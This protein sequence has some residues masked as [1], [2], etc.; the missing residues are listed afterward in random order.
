MV[1][2]RPWM[3]VILGM[4]MGLVLVLILG[5]RR[6]GGIDGFYLRVRAEL[7]LP[8]QEAFVPTPLPTPTRPP[9]ATVTPTAI[10][11]PPTSTATP[12][13][14]AVHTPEPTETLPPTPTPAPTET[15]TPTPTPSFASAEPRVELTGLRHEWQ[16]WNNCGPA[17]LATLMSYYGS[18]LRQADVAAVI[19]PDADVRH[20]PYTQILK[21]ARSQG[22]EAFAR[23]NGTA[24]LLKLFVS[25]DMPVMIPTWHVDAKGTGMGHYRVVTGY[26]D[27]LGEWILY[28]S[29]ESRGI[30]RDAPYRGI[31]MSYEQLE[32]YW[33]VRNYTY[34]VIVPQERLQ[35]AEAIIGEDMDN[36]VMWNASL[37]RAQRHL[38]TNRDD[39]FAWFSLG[40]NL[41]AHERYEE[42]AGAFDE[43]RM[44]GL[45]FRMMWYQSGPFTAYYETGRLQEV[46]AL[47]DATIEVTEMVES[48]HY[49]RGMA[50][51]GLGDTDGARRA[52]ERALKLRADF[53][54]AVAALDALG[55]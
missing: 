34:L 8:R 2:F 45:P 41:L 39:A 51:A 17:S 50:L 7:P 4:A 54:E 48:L 29:L 32:E 46:L 18:G 47:A 53:P 9:T 20:V 13:E 5:S 12:T 36:Q 49:W 24:E 11:A 40:G 38:D 25:N 3:L 43:A 16:T 37:E 33:Q 30:S 19:H 15:P 44:I 52:F 26:D 35:L 55:E 42:A 14:T 28:D 21:F 10:P 31:R 23:V 27:A 1:R 6:Y 22:F